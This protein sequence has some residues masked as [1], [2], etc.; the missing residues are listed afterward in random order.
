[1]KQ[2][3][4]RSVL[5]NGMS[6][7]KIRKMTPNQKKCYLQKMKRK[8]PLWKERTEFI[9]SY[10][11][12]KEVARASNDLERIKF[13]DRSLS[14]L[15]IVLDRKELKIKRARVIKQQIRWA[16]RCKILK[17]ANGYLGMFVIK[18]GIPKFRSIHRLMFEH[19]LGRELNSI[20]IVHHIDGNKLNNNL[21]NLSLMTNSEHSKLH[22]FI[23]RME[24]NNGQTDL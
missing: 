3:K 6:E 16:Q 7:S 14:L 1:M 18:D 22:Q 12:A 4:I 2:I 21:D 17:D 5:W 20:E 11:E 13:L 9:K 8:H 24:K 23:K 10:N 19:H 15:M